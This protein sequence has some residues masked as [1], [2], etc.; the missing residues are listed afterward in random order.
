VTNI[1]Y[2]AL[3]LIAR[4]PLDR[5]LTLILGLLAR[6]EDHEVV[7]V[8]YEVILRGLD[9]DP[10]PLIDA[11]LKSEDPRT[12]PHLMELLCRGTWAQEHAFNMLTS[13]L[14]QPLALPINDP[15]AFL[16][17]CVTLMENG[18]LTLVHGWLFATTDAIRRA[19][20]ERLR[21][22]LRDP[23]RSFPP[24]P[25]DFISFHLANGD[26]A[27]R[28]LFY[29]LVGMS[30]QSA[31][32]PMVTAQLLKESDEAALA[33]GREALRRLISEAPVLERT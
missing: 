1:R 6:E 23:N 9:R 4:Y 13:L 18:S 5:T 3:R 28:T 25:L 24:L 11:A 17:M 33:A 22:A 20:L 16:R 19:L 2:L 15:Q 27:S 7:S 29:E 30:L 14:R 8:A 10:R 12:R 31:G 26:A 32:I 21:D